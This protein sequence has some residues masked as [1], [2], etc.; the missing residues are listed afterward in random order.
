ME[1]IHEETKKWLDISGK[2]RKIFKKQP[3][4]RGHHG[5]CKPNVKN[6]F[7]QIL[8]NILKMI[9]AKNEEDL[10]ENKKKMVD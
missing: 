8:V 1:R 4:L 2:N 7:L 6:P 5:T 10:V 9:H 3:T